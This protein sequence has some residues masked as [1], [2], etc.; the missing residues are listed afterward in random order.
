MESSSAPEVAPTL[1]CR[2]KRQPPAA[3]YIASVSR[4]AARGSLPAPPGTTTQA[5]IVY[6][7]DQI[8]DAKPHGDPDAPDSWDDLF[9]EAISYHGR[10]TRME[11]VQLAAFHGLPAEL[12]DRWLRSAAERELVERINDFWR[13]AR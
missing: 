1:A 3:T 4:S 9:L 10:R 12:V 7:E 8:M 11:L 13:V 6:V 5:L 2:L